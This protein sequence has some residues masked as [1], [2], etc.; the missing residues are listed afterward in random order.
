[1]PHMTLCPG[2]GDMIAPEQ[3]VKSANG[4]CPDCART[5]TKRKNA[6]QA[7]ARGLISAAQRHRVMVRDGYRCVD[8]GATTQLS[9]DH[10]VPVVEAGVRRFADHELAVRCK[11]CNGRLGGGLSRGGRGYVSP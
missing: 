3:A 2:C 7:K 8:C 1:M 10:I 5:Y 9:V 11:P 4:R 6:R